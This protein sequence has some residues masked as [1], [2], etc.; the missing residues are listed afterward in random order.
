MLHMLYSGAMRNRIILTS[1]ILAAAV[2]CSKTSKTS[3][4]PASSPSTSPA[5]TAAPATPPVSSPVAAPSAPY[6]GKPSEFVQTVT[7]SK[8]IAYFRLEST[9]GTSETGGAAYSSKPGVTLSPGAPINVPGN[10]CAVLNGKDGA[11][12]TTQ[13]GGIGAAGSIMAWVMLNSLPSKNDH[14]LYV[15]GISENGNDFDLQFEHDDQLKFFTSGGG[16]VDYKPDPGTLAGTWHMIVVTMDTGSKTRAIYW[17]GKLGTVDA[18]GG[19][20]NKPQLFAIGASTVFGG[21]FFN[22]SIDE[23]ALWDR[24]LTGAE[25]AKLYG[26]V[27]VNP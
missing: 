11:I 20:P 1:L 7:A 9:S 12:S 19:L 3:E 2:S 23:V 10:Q 26:S 22:G 13:K 27:T 16:S 21:R 17:D 25:V 5:S 4:N 15:A 24:A 18:V 14:V 6:T 8:P